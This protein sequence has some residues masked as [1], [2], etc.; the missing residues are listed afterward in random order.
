MTA[1]AKNEA[2]AP[3]AYSYSQIRC[4]AACPLRY[5]YVYVDGWREQPRR[6]ALWFGR[7]FEDALAVYFRR[8][9]AQAELSRGWSCH[10]DEDLEYSRNEK[11]ETMYR[12]GQRLLERFAADSRV[13]VQPRRLQLKMERRLPRGRRFLGYI[14]A[15]GALDGRPTVLDWKTTSSRYPE[16][17]DG[18]ISLDPQLI[19]YA[20][21]SGIRNVALVVFL[22]K[23]VAEIQYLQ[24]TISERQIETWERLVEETVDRIEAGVFPAH[25]GIRFPSSPCPSCAH[26]GLCLEDPALVARNL[27]RQQGGDALDWVDELAA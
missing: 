16:T 12:Q 13:R 5:R 1:T 19:C 3:A 7:V 18:L 6:A 2:P 26:L 9:N 17:P 4:Y 15:I 23:Q 8:G 14:D 10:R 25:S 11:W 20:W 22:R 24:A 21:L 27:V